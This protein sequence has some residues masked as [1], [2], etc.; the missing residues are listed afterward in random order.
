ML[1]ITSACP[2]LELRG[3]LLFGEIINLFTSVEVALLHIRIATIIYFFWAEVATTVLLRNYANLN[4]V[5]NTY[6]Y[7]E[8]AIWILSITEQCWVLVLTTES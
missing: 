1:I 6:C 3:G 4:T 5:L 7:F 8:G 2:H